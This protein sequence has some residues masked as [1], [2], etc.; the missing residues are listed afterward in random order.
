[1]S[2]P[3]VQR[4][5]DSL[6]HLYEIQRELGG[7]AMSRV[8]V[9]RE[10]SLRRL[11]VIK[12][13]PAELAAA[14]SAER[15]RQEV[16]VLAQLQHPNIV[17]LLTA[18]EVPDL[19]R[20]GATGEY[21]V[22]PYVEGETL[23]SHMDRVGPLPVAEVIS[24]LRDVARALRQAH[25][26]GVVH[27]DIK[28]EN[29]LWSGGTAVVTDFGIAKAVAASALPTS[30]DANR[31]GTP[32]L[33]GAG[34]VL[35][36]PLYVAP[37]QAV[38]DPSTDH[39]AD[40]YALGVVAWEMLVGR[41]PFIAESAQQ[42]IRQHIVAIAD[43]LHSTR[44][45]IPQWL[46]D[47]IARLMSKQPGQRPQTAQEML[48]IL[49][50]GG[51]A[52][53]EGSRIRRLVVP[54]GVP[55]LQLLAAG[56][57]IMWKRNDRA[58]GPNV[59]RVLVAT[60]ANRT[61]RTDLNLVGGLA[62]DWIARQIMQSGLADVMPAQ[63]FESGS[64]S[65]PVAR[66]ARRA[67]AGTVVDGSYYLGADDSLRFELQVLDAR[68]GRVLR[69]LEPVQ[70]SVARLQDG[71]ITLQQRV[72]GAL[73]AL[74]D[75]AFASY[76]A[77]EATPSLAAYTE[78]VQ[79]QNI[80]WG[81]RKPRSDASLDSAIAH[82]RRA[83]TLDSTFYTAT[84][85]VAVGSSVVNR[86][87]VADSVTQALASRR[88]DF[89]TWDRQLFDLVVSRC[90]GDWATALQVSEQRM[91]AFPRSTHVRYLLAVYANFANHPRR[92][93]TALDSLNPATDLAWVPGPEPDVRYWD[94]RA[95]AHVLLQEYDSAL[96]IAQRLYDSHPSNRFV[97][98]VQAL[99]LATAGRLS[100]LNSMVNG[101]FATNTG[102]MPNDVKAA[103]LRVTRVLAAYGYDSAAQSLAER[104][105]QTSGVVDAA[106]S[107]R[108]E[109]LELAHRL[110]EAAELA[111]A[112]LRRQPD[113]LGFVRA[114]GRVAA[115]QGDIKTSEAIDARLS[116]WEGPFLLG[117]PELA[118][119]EIAALQGEPE[120]AVALLS[121]FI[122]RGGGSASQGP[123]MPL[124]QS[125]ALASL[126]GNA[127]FE[128]LLRPNE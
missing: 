14:V 75:T 87:H 94:Q 77:P 63:Q 114:M 52:S 90:R 53:T 29:I 32:R 125:P 109:L 92:A 37:E 17:P 112:Q 71:L 16:R 11:V 47:L 15:F 111:R 61:G 12:V 43:P 40:L 95:Q 72:G 105:L 46:A 79:A 93:L 67:G 28:P 66:L 19:Y 84:L 44:A 117:L 64:E 45:D 9:A 116:R 35:G 13:L 56:F 20:P 103:L 57:W 50:S 36:T 62:S 27:R 22:M 2:D 38:G 104:L 83:A 49:E 82:F 106:D 69:A 120:R 30:S 107:N 124:R 48:R 18:G 98:N 5:S 101:I 76:A 24:I 41:P 102:S 100:E 128:A 6:R 89:A 59:H 8:F 73:A 108:V 54:L 86:C 4:L 60:L 78:Y 42:V 127:G 58:R 65:G 119:A 123:V 10:Q 97:W 80:Y 91:R 33:T 81:A 126:H 7:G 115:R 39:R 21:Y 68:S 99:A 55:A 74:M 88:S 26:K 1:M 3:F 96:A 113:N 23:R 31:A 110:P 25:G 34:T 70:S 85:W 51:A 121:E 122:Q 118:R